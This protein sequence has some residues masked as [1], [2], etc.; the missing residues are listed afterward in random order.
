MIIASSFFTKEQQ[1]HIL[2]AIK[3][4]EE[5]TSGEIRVHIETNLSG[6]VLDRAAWIFKRIGMHKTSVR[7]GVLF[8]LAVNNRQ[9]AIIGDKGINSKV[10]EDFWEKAKELLR[11]NFTEGKFTE[12]L[13]EG[14]HLAG[15]QLKGNFPH[16]K[17]DVNELPD[18]ISFDDPD[19]VALR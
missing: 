8:Y 4:A 10:S 17:D 14:I 16:K 19:Y 11:K 5:E 6:S 12:G 13:V 18:E 15:L 3:E 7:N 2:A 1:A 9:F